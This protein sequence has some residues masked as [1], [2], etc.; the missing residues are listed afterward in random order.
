MKISKFCYCSVHAKLREEG[1]RIGWNLCAITSIDVSMNP[2]IRCTINGR[3]NGRRRWNCSVE[4]IR[5][6]LRFDLIDRNQVWEGRIKR[7]ERMNARYI[8]LSIVHVRHYT[9]SRL[10]PSFPSFCRD[11]SLWIVCHVTRIELPCAA[12]IKIVASSNVNPK[13]QSLGLQGKGNTSPKRKKR[14]VFSLD[15]RRLSTTSLGGGRENSRALF[16]RF[17]WLDL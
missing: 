8:C 9:L 2:S 14:S 4:I 7:V 13:V 17:F 6:P 3:Y 12:R 11:P 5:A 10:A 1:R 15:C 16:Y